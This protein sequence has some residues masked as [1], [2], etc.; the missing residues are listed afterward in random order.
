MAFDIKSSLEAIQTHIS[1]SGVG[2]VQIGEPSVPP[3]PNTVL[4]AIWLE[5]VESVGTTLD[6][7]IEVWT[8]TVRYYMALPKEPTSGIELSMA[9][10]ISEVSALLM[11]DFTLGAKIRNIDI[12]G[13]YGARMRTRVGH[14]ELGRIMCR[15][16]DLVL[17]LIV[18]DSAVL[19]P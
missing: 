17:P 3:P 8:V 7:S 6:G 11:G 1:K 2:T 12:G 14:V 4:A 5:S 10:A 13:Q 18:D 16:A 9:K 15:T 19:A